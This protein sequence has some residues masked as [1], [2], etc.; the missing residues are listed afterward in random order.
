MRKIITILHIYV[1]E[2]IIYSYIYIHIYESRDCCCTV[3]LTL[4]ELSYQNGERRKFACMTESK[5]IHKT[6]YVINLSYPKHSK[7]TE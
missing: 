3:S 4:N 7:S 6:P 1:Y 5:S 2:D